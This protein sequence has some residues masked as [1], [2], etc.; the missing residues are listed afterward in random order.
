MSRLIPLK[1]AGVVY[2]VFDQEILA[3]GREGCSVLDFVSA[4]EMEE[5]W[6]IAN[7]CAALAA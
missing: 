1:E 5:C 2:E 4:K 6:T 3:T 7:M